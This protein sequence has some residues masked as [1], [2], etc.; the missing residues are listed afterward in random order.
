MPPS[1][2]AK[3]MRSDGSLRPVI[4]ELAA[5]SGAYIIVSSSG[6]T[7]DFGL[8]QSPRCHGRSRQIQCQRRKASRRLL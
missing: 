2:I 1:E 6:S 5:A 4:E 7:A 3:E 8:E